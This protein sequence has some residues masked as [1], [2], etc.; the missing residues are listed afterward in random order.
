M[1]SYAFRLASASPRPAFHF[2]FFEACFSVSMALCHTSG[3]PCTIH[4]THK[5]LFSTTFSLKIYGSHGTIHTFKNYFATMSSVFNFQ[6]NKR[7]PNG[8]FMY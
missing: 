2:F 1:T 8:P 6:P 4:G 3:V 5:S 7:Y